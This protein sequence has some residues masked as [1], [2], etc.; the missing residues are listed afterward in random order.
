MSF[1]FDFSQD[2]PDIRSVIPAGTKL[3]LRFTYAPGG[4]DVPGTPDNMKTGA[5]TK[6]KPSA[7]NPNPDTLYLKGEFTV[8]RG[9]YKG[10]KFWSNLT[11]FGGQR[12]ERGQSKG[13]QIT[14]STIRSMIDSSKGLSSKDESPQAAQQRVLPRGFIDLQGITFVAEAKVEPA[15]NG[16]PEKN[17]LGAI[18][19]IDNP[20]FPTEQ[21]LDNPPVPGAANTNGP[22]ALPGATAPAWAT[23]GGSAATPA[24][25]PTTNAGANGTTQTQAAAEPAPATPTQAQPESE[26]PG[27]MKQAA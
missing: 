15:R 17:G 3:L 26:L 23:Q 9:P 25:D 18:L 22:A 19:T 5:L 4:M 21:E 2:K 14:R 16:F 20:K 6:S 8:V 27:W 10:R 1:S 13:G 12:D 7:E 11:V 24:A